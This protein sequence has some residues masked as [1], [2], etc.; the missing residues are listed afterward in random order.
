MM[1]DL[2][3]SSNVTTHGFVSLTRDKLIGKAVDESMPGAVENIKSL[4]VLGIDECRTLNGSK[5]GGS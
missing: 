1:S 4:F 5:L 2:D 3:F